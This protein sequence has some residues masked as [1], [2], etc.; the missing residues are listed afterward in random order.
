MIPVSANTLPGLLQVDKIRI[1]IFFEGILGLKK[2][3]LPFN[4]S[5][6]S[7]PLW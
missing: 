7:D 2:Y 5:F 3:E 1:K 4:I 6:L